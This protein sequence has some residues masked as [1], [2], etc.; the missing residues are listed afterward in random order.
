MTVEELA[1]IV[2]AL[3]RENSEQQSQ[4]E[5]MKVQITELQDLAQT[6]GNALIRLNN[7]NDGDVPL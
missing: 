2:V 5:Q 6:F 3:N 7:I 4:I 1:A